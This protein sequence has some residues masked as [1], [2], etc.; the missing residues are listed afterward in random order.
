MK[1]SVQ[2]LGWQEGLLLEYSGHSYCGWAMG[3]RYGQMGIREVLQR[4]W[5]SSHSTHFQTD[6]ICWHFLEAALSHRWSKLFSCI[7]HFLILSLQPTEVAEIKVL[8][9][10]LEI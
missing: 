9:E 7:L 2:R 10:A 4:L 8:S 1:C 6:G 5:S 3:H